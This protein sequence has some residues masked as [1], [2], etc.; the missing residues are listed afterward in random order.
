M[1]QTI[2][3][4]FSCAF[5]LCSQTT[6]AQTKTTTS[7]VTDTIT[8]SG[9]CGECKSRIEDAAYVKGVKK[10]NWDKKTKL[11]TVT[12]TAQKTNLSTIAS[13]IAKIGHDSRLATASDKNYN[14]LPNCCAYR[15]GKCHHE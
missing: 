5:L 8:I 15:N 4:L 1:K 2:M 13:A 10:A 9:N 6:F 14:K 3:A 7:V 12:Y 11:L